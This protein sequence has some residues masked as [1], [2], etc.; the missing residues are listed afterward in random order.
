MRTLENANKGLFCSDNYFDIPPCQAYTGQVNVDSLCVID[1]DTARSKRDLSKYNC[2]HFYCDDYKFQSIW[3]Y[4]ERYI[5]F[6]K[7]KH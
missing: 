3:N 5:D 1:F 4:P 6:L 7:K 2:I